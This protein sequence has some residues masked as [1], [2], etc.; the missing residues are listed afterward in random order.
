MRPVL[1]LA[2]FTAIALALRSRF[3]PAPTAAG[4]IVMAVGIFGLAE[5]QQMSGIQALVTRPLA[6][7]LL[8]LWLFIAASYVESW[9]GGRGD[10]HSGPLVGRYAIGSWIAGTTVMLHLL[11]RGLPEWLP[12]AAALG[13]LACGLW[14]WYLVVA[15][16]AFPGVARQSS[17]ELVS[18]VVLLSTVST[19]SIAIAAL[20]L[21]PRPMAWRGLAVSLIA[22]GFVLYVVNAV[23]VVRSFF[24][25][26][27]WT[28]A[29]DWDNSNCI[30]H[31]AMSI[32]GLAVVLWGASPPAVVL[33]TWLYVLAVFVA[34]ESVELARLAVRV[35]SYGWRRGAF[36]YH[37]T[38]WS[39]NFTWG[40]FYAFTLVYAHADPG[41][42]IDW[43]RA[44]QQPIL[45]FGPYVGLL[46]LLVETGLCLEDNL[47]RRPVLRRAGGV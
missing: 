34:V 27:N 28:L 40:M 16:K 20:D 1:L 13:V 18:G 32:T 7:G 24:R 3:R 8:V 17:R 30:L 23:V 47:G 36:S 45:S 12:L 10:E 46:L 37:V 11:L 38:Q 39:R 35:R 25:A 22:A 6:L 29:D 21:L 5:L 31:G 33:T 42:Q 14:L 19:Q 44:L 43:V 2:A 9:L 15:G 26:R 4:S 41:P